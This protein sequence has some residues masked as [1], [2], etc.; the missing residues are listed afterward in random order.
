MLE[1]CVSHL[2]TW[3]LR[4]ELRRLGWQWS[5]MN[6]CMQDMIRRRSIL[7]VTQD[8][9]HVGLLRA[10]EDHMS[11]DDSTKPNSLGD[12]VDGA[13]GGKALKQRYNLSQQLLH[14]TYLERAARP[15]VGVRLPIGFTSCSHVNI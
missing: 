7:Q 1:N 12:M 3:A 11:L 10:S 5:D 13:R 2:E 4:Y 14:C 6:T 15:Q 9:D 8:V